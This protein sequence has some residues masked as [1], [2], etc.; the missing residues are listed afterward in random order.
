MF[1][2]A[3]TGGRTAVVSTAHLWVADREGDTAHRLFRARLARVSVHEFGH[4]LGFLHCEHPR[5][6]MKESLN[7]SMLDRTRATFC[8]EC[9]Q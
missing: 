8:P 1:G 4:T 3:W 9:L 7:L 6:V 2:K 5:C